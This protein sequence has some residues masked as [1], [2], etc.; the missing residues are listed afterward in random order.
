MQG[1][2]LPGRLVLHHV[3]LRPAGRLTCRSG[4]C[5]CQPVELQ[6]HGTLGGSTAP[7]CSQGTY[8]EQSS[9]CE[10]SHGRL[11]SGG[12]AWATAAQARPVPPPAWQW[13]ICGSSAMPQQ[14]A[15]KSQ[16]WGLMAHLTSSDWLL[17]EQCPAPALAIPD[18]QQIR[19][20]VQ[21]LE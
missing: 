12:L 3:N 1:D 10:G 15:A 17:C 16:C 8:L 4:G 2:R 7:R 9:A 13:M 14:T 5:A 6:W 11:C 19:H 21:P 18:L 20:A